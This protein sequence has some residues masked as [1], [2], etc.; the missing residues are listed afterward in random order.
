MPDRNSKAAG[1]S[2]P[3][4]ASELENR[5]GR[6]EWPFENVRP[7]PSTVGT[8]SMTI[9]SERFRKHRRPCGQPA[10]EGGIRRFRPVPPQAGH[11]ERIKAT[12]SD[13]PFKSTGFATYPVPPQLG[14]SSGATPSP[15]RI[16]SIVPDAS[17]KCCADCLALRITNKNV[18]FDSA[19]G[20]LVR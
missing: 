2:R 5:K 16:E 18:D 8:R 12:P 10:V 9:R 15:L 20:D 14:Q 3:S 13:L 4:V 17:V 7:G 19:V 11:F 6:A 1:E